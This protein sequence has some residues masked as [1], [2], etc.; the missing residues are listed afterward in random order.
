MPSTILAFLK[1]PSPSMCTKIAA[2]ENKPDDWHTDL[3]YGKKAWNCE[4]KEEFFWHYSLESSVQI[5]LLLGH[6]TVDE[7]SIIFRDKLGTRKGILLP[8]DIM[9]YILLL[10]YMIKW[11][12]SKNTWDGL[13]YEWGFK[14][15]NT[16]RDQNC[17][18][19]SRYILVDTCIA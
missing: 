7:I 19:F 1:L 10:F 3:K 18:D 17:F 4:K 13:Q 12:A 14:T 5:V 15:D 9:K 16:I 8:Q 11:L 6:I 2:F